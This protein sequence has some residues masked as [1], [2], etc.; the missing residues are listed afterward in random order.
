MLTFPS[1]VC[2][3]VFPQHGKCPHLEVLLPSGLEEASK[4]G[5]IFKVLTLID[6]DLSPCRRDL[7]RE[8]ARPQKQGPR[9]GRLGN[10]TYYRS[11]I[12][13]A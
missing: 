8:W 13:M 3:T 6:M 11:E 1:L 2:Q 10:A 7:T 4:T 5:M 9:R 12:H